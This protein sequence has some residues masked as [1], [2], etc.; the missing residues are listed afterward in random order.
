MN[1]AIQFSIARLWADDLGCTEANEMKNS[2][3]EVAEKTSFFYKKKTRGERES[4][5]YERK[6]SSLPSSSFPFSLL[7]LPSLTIVLGGSKLMQPSSRHEWKKAGLVI[8]YLIMWP[9]Q[10]S[11]YS[12]RSC[13]AVCFVFIETKNVIVDRSN[14]YRSIKSWYIQCLS[15]KILCG[16]VLNVY[17]VQYRRSSVLRI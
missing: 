4:T 9:I 7:H 14:L 5:Q 17:E 10:G 8:T 6:H 15:R 2:L 13:Y 16:K 12:C 3:L 1:L 11:S